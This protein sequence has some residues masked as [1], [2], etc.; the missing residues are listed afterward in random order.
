MKS[1][2]GVCRAIRNY[3]TIRLD[4][5]NDNTRPMLSDNSPVGVLVSSICHQSYQCFSMLN[6]SGGTQDCLWCKDQ[7]VLVRANI[8]L[9]RAWCQRTFRFR[10]Q[11]WFRETPRFWNWHQNSKLAPEFDLNDEIARSQSPSWE[12]VT[13]HMFHC[14]HYNNSFCMTTWRWKWLHV[15]LSVQRA[16]FRPFCIFGR[17]PISRVFAGLDSINA[18]GKSLHLDLPGCI[19]SESKRKYIYLN[20]PLWN[21]ASGCHYLAPK[22]AFSSC[23]P[24]WDGATFGRN[25]G[26]MERIVF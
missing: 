11:S 9:H 7:G 15:S 5:F 14:P 12:V 18:K 22:G 13:W 21:L 4:L 8:L 23:P 16:D 1:F 10:E 25:Y 2:R 6:A 3:S 20:K 24:F 17:V 26:Q 19:N